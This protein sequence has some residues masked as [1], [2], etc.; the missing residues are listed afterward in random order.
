MACAGRDPAPVE[1]PVAA[2]DR[3]VHVCANPDG[4]LVDPS[5]DSAGWLVSG[6]TFAEGQG[7]LAAFTSDDICAGKASLHVRLDTTH[8]RFPLTVGVRALGPSPAGVHVVMD[9]VPVTAS[10]LRPRDYGRDIRVE[11]S[12]APEGHCQEPPQTYRVGVGLSENAVCLA[13]GDVVDFPRWALFANDGREN[14]VG[15]S[16]TLVDGNVDLETS[17]SGDVAIAGG[18]T[19]GTVAFPNADGTALEIDV[20]RDAVLSPADATGGGGLSA[21]I[22]TFFDTTLHAGANLICLPLGMRD[23]TPALQINL[24]AP[25]QDALTPLNQHAVVHLPIVRTGVCVNEDVVDGEFNDPNSWLAVAFGEDRA[26]V[27]RGVATMAGCQS[28]TVLGTMTVPQADTAGGAALRVTYR[29]HGNVGAVVGVDNGDASGLHALEATGSAF[30]ERTVCLSHQS[31]GRLR[32]LRFAL[33]SPAD[34]ACASRGPDE[35]TLEV[36]RVRAY[37]DPTCPR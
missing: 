22:A 8:C 20:A 27:A 31:P 11:L 34:V 17:H 10:C 13:A 26:I 30:E 29:L 23:T 19:S 4:A 5:E 7:A 18:P 9:G 35:P 12:I 25:G 2:P 21:T 6:G 33:G 14:P 28:P 37:N 24:I 16:A 32:N 15:V 1:L 36:A 3:V